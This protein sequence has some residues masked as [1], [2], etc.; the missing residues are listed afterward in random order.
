MRA[1]TFSRLGGPEVFEVSEL[2]EPQ[3]G[4]GEVRIRVARKSSIPASSKIAAAL[5]IA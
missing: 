1:V 3:P 5:S 2:P 4:P